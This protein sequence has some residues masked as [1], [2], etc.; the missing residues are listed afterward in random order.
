MSARPAPRANPHKSTASIF[1]VS[2]A[3]SIHLSLELLEA[4]DALIGSEAQLEQ[5]QRRIRDLEAEIL[6]SREATDRLDELER[7][8]IGRGYRKYRQL[9]QRFGPPVK[10][11]LRKLR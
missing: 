1:V 4:R 6:C 9:R 7:S 10:A 8:V 11:L 2:D 3:E 5:V